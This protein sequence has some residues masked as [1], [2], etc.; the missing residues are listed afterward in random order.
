MDFLSS[1]IK[2]LKPLVKGQEWSINHNDLFEFLNCGF[3]YDPRT[4]IENVSKIPMGHYIV[5]EKSKLYIYKYFDAKS[6]SEH[7]SSF[8]ANPESLFERSVNSPNYRC[9]YWFAV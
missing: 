4:G 6:D 5:W 3:L 2:G 9:K 7:Y 1:E 8:S